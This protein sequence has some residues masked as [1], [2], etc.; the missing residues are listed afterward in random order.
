[1]APP[2]PLP[3]SILPMKY[4][5]ALLLVALILVI[6][7]AIKIYV[8]T[9]FFIGEEVR[10]ASNWARLHFLE[11]EG[12]AF[13]LKLSEGSV[14]KMILTLFRL[15]AVI[16][17]FVLLRRLTSGR[18]KTGLIICGSLILAGAAGNLID[19]MFYG[20]IFSGSS[21]HLAN[22]ATRVPWG[23]GYAPFLHG[24]V[25][26][27]FYFPLFSFQWPDWMPFLAG[28][29]FSFFDPVFN[30]ADAA[31]SVGVIALLLFQKSLLPQKPAA[32]KARTAPHEVEVTERPVE[33]TS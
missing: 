10:M 28:K 14:G 11:N 24:K 6:D 21:P 33:H 13:G 7:Q 9:H 27:M 31:I 2:L 22:V 19:S 1:M 20:Q 3:P 30:F 5:H 4:R 8:K 25:V 16:A 12:M 23:Q 32:P 17:G 26:D 15:V 29:T 18:Y